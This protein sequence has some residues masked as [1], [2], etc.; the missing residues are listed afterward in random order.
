MRDDQQRDLSERVGERVRIYQRGSAWH[1][2]Y[3]MGGKQFRQ[4]LKTTN[5]KTA[6]HRAAELDRQLAAGEMPANKVPVTIS[7]A[8]DAYKAYLTAEK[9]AAKTIAKYWKV[10]ERVAKLAQSMGRHL[11]AQVDLVF[12]DK[13]RA[14]RAE[15]CAARTIYTEITVIRQL[16]KFAVTRG[17]VEKD[18]LAGLRM[19]KPK[20]TRQP[21]FDDEEIGK[22]L[23]LARPPHD[24]TFLLL[25]ETG[26]RFGEAQWLTW[27]DIDFKSNVIHGRA[28]DHWR[29]K[30]GDERAVPISPKLALFLRGLLRHGRWVLTALPTTKYPEEGRQISER[31]ALASLKRVLSKLGIEGKLHSFRHS[32]ISRC[33]TAGIEEAVV[34]T[35]V[36]HVDPTIMRFY[37]YIT[38]KVSQERIKLWGGKNPES[39]SD[40]KTA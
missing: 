28:K 32:F 6:I 13:Y 11:I 7:E 39:G 14:M 33:L 10:F 5:K 40:S 34:R 19:K 12:V 2:N 20:P 23:E 9:R 16:V 3:Q 1:A 30:T 38:S 4:S 21:C 22:I 35:W 26:L 37:T 24:A 18:P 15:K 29:P 8:I 31:R 17:L 25:S 27:P 36:G